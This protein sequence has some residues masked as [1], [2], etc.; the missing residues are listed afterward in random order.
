MA[1]S[2]ATARVSPLPLSTFG[3][4]ARVFA[5]LLDR[6]LLDA[7][8]ILDGGG[9]PLVCGARDDRGGALPDAVKLRIHHPRFYARVL[10]EGNL[11]F[12]EAF[13]DGDFTVSRGEL[14]QLLTALLRN[15][16]D[17]RLRR[18]PRTL[19]RVIALQATNLIRKR[20][21]HH[22]QRHYDLGPELFAAF[23]DDARVYSCGYAVSTDDDL[24]TLQYQKLDRIGRKLEL[25][26]GERLLDIG[27]GMGGL[28]IHAA[29][30]FG[31]HGVGITNS[32]DHARV[33]NEGI[34]A[35]GLADR[36][37]I[38][39]R[40]HRTVGDPGDGPYDKIVSVG[41]LEHLP[42]RE[43]RR[44]FDNIAKALAPRGL[45]LVHAIGATAPR[46]EHDPFI[47][48]Y[49]F[50]GAGQM[51]LSDVARELE[52]HRFAIRDVE[53][54][55]RHYGY[56]L[57]HWLRRFRRNAPSLDPVRYDDSF[58]RMWEYYLHCCVAAAFGSDAAVYQV[59]F[60]KDYAAPM[61][62]QRVG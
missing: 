42:R 1:E 61:P 43:Y 32:E 35:A 39:L 58:R 28:L 20:Q 2:M 51:L 41:M 29:R 22:V 14:H 8:V 31:V 19:A 55:I 44:Y 57:L 30:H 9:E 34:A 5:A 17:Q 49:I 10:G 47:Q 24:E 62:L 16:V 60:A 52:R 38:E 12:G 23:L 18:D 11:G 46:V 40:D 13:M 21:W 56:T 45:G 4:P 26:P 33:G 37:R 53:N 15:R 25:A 36:V 54:I 7:T 48:K 59:L 50:P 27:C 3:D 6:H